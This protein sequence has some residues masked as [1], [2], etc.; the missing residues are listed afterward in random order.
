VDTQDEGSSAFSNSLL[1]EASPTDAS[2]GEIVPSEYRQE[3]QD[4]MTR[5]RE[6]DCIR[7]R[8]ED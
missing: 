5:I 8:C 2:S 3:V 4:F 6:S 7:I 1:D